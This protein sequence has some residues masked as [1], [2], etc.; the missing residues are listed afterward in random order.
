MAVRPCA[1]F[2]RGDPRAQWSLE[3]QAQAVEPAM[4]FNG[5]FQMFHNFYMGR[6][7]PLDDYTFSLNEACV[8]GTVNNT[9]AFACDERC[10]EPH[11]EW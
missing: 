1:E 9:C 5:T 7:E 6:H 10:D 11:G 8:A 2:P 4:I 3:R